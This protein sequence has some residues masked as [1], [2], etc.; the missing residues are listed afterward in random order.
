MFLWSSHVLFGIF[1]KI[2]HGMRICC[3]WSDMVAYE[4]PEFVSWQIKLEKILSVRVFE[5]AVI[6]VG[7]AV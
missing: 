6:L 4:L 3:K 1:K 2:W 7:W 5:W